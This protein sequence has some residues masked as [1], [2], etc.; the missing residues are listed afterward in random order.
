MHRRKRDRHHQMT[1]NDR[2]PPQQTAPPDDVRHD[3]RRIRSEDIFA[4]TREVAIEHEGKLDRLQRT[5]KG[6][7]I[8]TK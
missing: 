4:D 2:Q 8:L 5:S 1:S 7:L 6:K 3:V